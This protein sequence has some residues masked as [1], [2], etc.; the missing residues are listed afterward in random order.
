MVMAIPSI[1]IGAIGKSTGLFI[2]R[3]NSNNSGTYLRERLIQNVVHLEG[4]LFDTQNIIKDK[5]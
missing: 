1:I 3:S 2:V 4:G 5:M